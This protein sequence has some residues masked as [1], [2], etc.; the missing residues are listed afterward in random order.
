MSS[1]KGV[2]KSIFGW[3]CGRLS[4]GVGWVMKETPKSSLWYLCMVPEM[5]YNSHEGDENNRGSDTHLWV[6][7]D[8]LGLHALVYTFYLN[9]YASLYLCHLHILCGIHI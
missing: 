6:T 5:G 1:G 7:E 8:Y 4:S 2:A 3:S 9:L